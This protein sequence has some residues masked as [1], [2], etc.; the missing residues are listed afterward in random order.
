MGRKKSILMEGQGG[1]PLYASCLQ[2]DTLE[3]ERTPPLPIGRYASASMWLPQYDLM[4]WRWFS[5]SRIRRPVLGRNGSRS[6]VAPY[7]RYHLLI[8][9]IQNALDGG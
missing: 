5:L 7:M 2:P 9:N 4:D 8:P 3:N 6:P 1:D